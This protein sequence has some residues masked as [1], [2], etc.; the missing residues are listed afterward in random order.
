MPLKPEAAAAAASLLVPSSRQPHV[1]GLVDTGRQAQQRQRQQQPDT[2]PAAHAASSS[3]QHEPGKEATSKHSSGRTPFSNPA[4]ASAAA[5]PHR[6]SSSSLL[7]AP[8]H[9]SLPQAVMHACATSSTH[10]ACMQLPPLLPHGMRR[11]A[12]ACQ[13]GCGF[14]CSSHSRWMALWR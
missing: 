7:K 4:A 5:V 14:R 9:S 1:A 11:R 6:G 13:T 2:V 8:Q 3:R 12:W 10:S